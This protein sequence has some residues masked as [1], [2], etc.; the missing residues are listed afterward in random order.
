[1]KY[2]FPTQG[3][4]L[5]AMAI[6]AKWLPELVIRFEKGIAD[7]GLEIESKQIRR[8]DG[9][10]VGPVCTIKSKHPGWTLE[11]RLGNTLAEFLTIDRD[12]RPVRLDPRLL[13]DGFASK[14][15]DDLVNGRLDIARVLATSRSPKEIRR[16][17]VKIGKNMARL[18]IWE[19]LDDK[20]PRKKRRKRDR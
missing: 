16:K 8:Y 13:D 10:E 20:K 2:D 11:L 9:N 3:E 6:T 17:M 19:M 12:A 4:M 7:L 14:K 1:M 15:L 18:R 5:A